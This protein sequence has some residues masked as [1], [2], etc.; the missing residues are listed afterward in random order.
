VFRGLQTERHTDWIFKQYFYLLL[1]IH[2]AENGEDRSRQACRYWN[3]KSLHS[4]LLISLPTC[5]SVKLADLYFL[6]SST[7]ILIVRR[8]L[9]KFCRSAL[10]G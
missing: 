6:H 7:A 5:E 2:L 1:I 4:L 3:W 9:E 8:V 10:Q